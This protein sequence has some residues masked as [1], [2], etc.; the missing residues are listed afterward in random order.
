M[1]K[2]CKTEEEQDSLIDIIFVM[3]NMQ[4]GDVLYSA[5]EKI[6]QAKQL[7]VEQIAKLIIAYFKTGKGQKNWILNLLVSLEMQVDQINSEIL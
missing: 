6:L 5:T 1:R 7:K 3:G 4:Q 2:P